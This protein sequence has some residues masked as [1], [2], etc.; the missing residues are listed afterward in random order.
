MANNVNHED[1]SDTD[2][3]DSPK[4]RRVKYIRDKNLPPGWKYYDNGRG[5]ICFRDGAGNR[6]SNRRKV[7]AHMFN[8]GGFSREAQYY[9]RDGLLDEGWCYHQELPPSWMYKQYNHKIEGVGTDILYILSP[10]GVIYRSKIKLKR[11][12]RELGL[13]DYD[14]KLLLDFKNEVSEETRKIEEPDSSWVY[15]KELVPLGWKRKKYSYKSGITKKMEEV[16]H[17]LT[18]DNIVL[19]GRKQVYDYMVKTGTFSREEFAKF[20]FNQKK[21]LREEK[22]LLKRRNKVDWGEWYEAAE[23]GEG[24]M[25]RMCYYKSQR[26]CQYRAPDG[27]KFQSRVLAIKYIKSEGGDVEFPAK[28]RKS[29]NKFLKE[30]KKPFNPGRRLN[31]KLVTVW[32]EW[33]S[34]EI[35]CLVGWQ[36][37]IGRKGDKRKIRYKSPGGFVFK[38]RGPLLRYLIENGLKSKDQLIILKKQL[39]TNQN[40]PVKDLLT[41]DKFIKNFD[42]DTN[43]LEFLK[44]RYENES[45]RDIPE[46]SDPKL[47]FGWVKKNINGVDYFRDPSGQ[48][49]FN[50]RRLVVD[51]LRR[52]Y[53][54]YSHDYLRGILEDSESDSDLTVSEEES[55]GEDI[56]ENN[57]KFGSKFEFVIC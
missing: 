26:K 1:Q 5:T 9:I 44:I 40:L 18:P 38:S 3:E 19:R 30:S 17:Y 28:R 20:H 56:E 4:R 33:R 55:D 8:T 49:V 31:G 46:V 16:Y 27:K 32:D 42:A 50:S 12:A 41:N 14:L 10:N 24:W 13:S 35:P 45:Y 47:P 29:Y 7:L 2:S 6:Y 34:D 21:S 37:S 51:H 23:L 39:K 48:H 11:H 54:D 22:S 52:N 25:S 57:N 53:L 15:D 43:Y 36:F